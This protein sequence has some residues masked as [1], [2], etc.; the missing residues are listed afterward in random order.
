MFM[1]FRFLILKTCLSVAQSCEDECSSGEFLQIALDVKQEE[2]SGSA[3]P[4]PHARG[5]PPQFGTTSEVWS[6]ESV[7]W[8]WHDPAGRFHN[9]L[10]GGVVIDRDSNLFLMSGKGLFAFNHLGEQLWHYEPEGG[11]NNEPT[12][13][14]DL[15]LGSSKAGIAFALER[16]TGKVRWTKKLAKDAGGDCGYPAAFDEVMVVGAK[17]NK[18]KL[19][20]GNLQ[21]FGLNA[22]TGEMLW[23]FDVDYPVWNLTPLFP[24]DETWILSLADC[25]HLSLVLF[26]S[27][28]I[29]NE[30]SNARKQ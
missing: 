24:G 30:R 15:V 5:K 17:M 28:K 26:G 21:V 29:I 22:S 4:W 3:H 23:E 19:T 1:L 9:I 14:E 25:H 27:P 10:A 12:L 2:L 11:S 20:G 18:K 7:K 8:M 6:N 16:L 13:H